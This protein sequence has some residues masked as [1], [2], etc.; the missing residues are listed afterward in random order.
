M[1]TPTRAPRSSALRART[2]APR[3]KPP[4][5]S[6]RASAAPSAGLLSLLAPVFR[7]SSLFSFVS[8]QSN[9][10]ES[11]R[12][13]RGHRETVDFCSDAQTQVTLA[14]R[15]AYMSDN[16]PLIPCSEY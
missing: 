6:F 4:T 13:N 1:R 7:S 15:A 10:R 11:F 9:A 16:R 2:R 12:L 8:L 3:Q 5:D 14:A